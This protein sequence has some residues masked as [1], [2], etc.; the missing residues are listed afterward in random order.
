MSSQE[1]QLQVLLESLH[2]LH[3]DSLTSEQ[4]IRALGA[5]RFATARWEDE[6]RR[7]EMAESTRALADYIVEGV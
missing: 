3:P 6:L 2:G 7:R 5:M 4:M 1:F